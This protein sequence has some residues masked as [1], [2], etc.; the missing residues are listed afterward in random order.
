M[1]PICVQIMECRHCCIYGF[2][3]R[4]YC[5]CQEEDTSRKERGIGND[6]RGPA[7]RVSRAD[8]QRARRVCPA[9]RLQCQRVQQSVYRHRLRH[10]LRD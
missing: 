9:E 8:Y 3:F 4:V 6:D 2:G 5:S 1:K 10:R 7:Q